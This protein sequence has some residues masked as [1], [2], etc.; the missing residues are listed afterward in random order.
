M[1]R[2]ACFERFMDGATVG[3]AI[4]TNLL[5]DERER[6]ERLDREIAKSLLP[7]RELEPFERVHLH[8][9]GE[10]VIAAMRAVRRAVAQKEFARNAL[11]DE[12]AVLIGENDDDG[13][14]LAGGDF[15][16]EGIQV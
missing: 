10:Q 6:V 8:V 16:F 15:G 2:N 1:Q 4:E 11:A 3:M 5:D 12:P 7:A 9:D 14:D 13:I